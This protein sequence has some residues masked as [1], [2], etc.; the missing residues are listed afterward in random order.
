MRTNVEPGFEAIVSLVTLDRLHS[1][2]EVF[3]CILLSYLLKL[4]AYV[5]SPFV[6]E[7]WYMYIV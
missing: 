2:A 3:S 1:H 7:G 5:P 4:L 6:L